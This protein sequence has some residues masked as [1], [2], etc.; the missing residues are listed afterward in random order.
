LPIFRVIVRKLCLPRWSSHSAVELI[1]N[2]L[3]NCHTIFYLVG[4]SVRYIFLGSKYLRG[5]VALVGLSLIFCVQST[6][7]KK[8]CNWKIWYKRDHLILRKGVLGLFWTTYIRTFSLHKV[9]KNSH[10]LNHPLTPRPLRKI[11]IVPK[12]Q[13]EYL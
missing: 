9:R 5:R 13:K 11:K 8:Y 3:H 10:F 4:L 12:L 6:S 7:E 2:F 1:V